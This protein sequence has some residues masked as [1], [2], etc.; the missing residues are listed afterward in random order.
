MNM[1]TCNGRIQNINTNNLMN[2]LRNNGVGD[3]KETNVSTPTP[4]NTIFNLFETSKNDYSSETLNELNQST[5]NSEDH[6]HPNTQEQK[7][8]KT[9][10]TEEK[11]ND[12]DNG[13]E[14]KN[15][16]SEKNEKEEKNE[17][18]GKGRERETEDNEE[19]N[20]NE[21]ENEDKDKEKF[22]EKL[23]QYK[24]NRKDSYPP[25]RYSTHYSSQ[26]S[27]DTSSH[28][29]FQSNDNIF[30]QN[31]IDESEA[32]S[33]EEVDK[34][35]EQKERKRELE[36]DKELRNLNEKPLKKSH[37]HLYHEENYYHKRYSTHSSGSLNPNPIPNSN[38]LSVNT[39]MDNDLFTL[40]EVD[41]ILEGNKEDKEKEMEKPKEKERVSKLKGYRHQVFREDS[42]PIKR[43]SNYLSTA[44]KVPNLG[45]E[46]LS[47]KPNNFNPIVISNRNSN[48]SPNIHRDS[49]T[50]TPVNMNLIPKNSSSPNIALA[51]INP[52]PMTST[53]GK[54]NIALANINPMSMALA[55]SPNSNNININTIGIPNYIM[56]SEPSSY[57]SSESQYNGS[58]SFSQSSGRKFSFPHHSL[59]QYDQFK[60]HPLRKT[61]EPL[62]ITQPSQQP[63][64][65]QS[66]TQSQ[67]Q[68]QNQHQ[69]QHQNQRQTHFSLHS[70]TTTKIS[71][72]DKPALYPK[73]KQGDSGSK[74]ISSLNKP[75]LLNKYKTFVE[76]QTSEKLSLNYFGRSKSYDTKLDIFNPGHPL[77][78][79]S[80]NI[81][82]LDEIIGIDNEEEEKK[83]KH[84]SI[85]LKNNLH[86]IKSRTSFRMGFKDNYLSNDILIDV[87][88]QG[89]PFHVVY[90]VWQIQQKFRS[91]RK[92]KK[93]I[94]R[95]KKF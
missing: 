85:N 74:T 18:K 58:L 78:D 43:N 91:S 79:I 13:E 86:R 1:H 45:N 70:S 48:S 72:D 55:D 22:K 63:S 83:N 88:K 10:K 8:E 12:D 52:M 16:K 62:P 34:I 67:T 87:N 40:N 29:N 2:I 92:E 94:E 35:L 24:F 54:P 7:I 9:E 25:K 46:T 80:R 27:S 60:I 51:N 64:Q 69:H 84:R 59:S 90:A 31:R 36:R 41:R 75:K 50:V 61:T 38:F 26:Y 66:Q 21:N 19:K 77:D 39:I 82:E 37:P 15:E 30:D 42:Y 56:T 28:S 81:I 57:E 68:Q 44:T 53:T 76:T 3:D 17:K 95:K 23:T 93:I 20:K 5:K 14:G 71:Y 32:F 49:L 33:L 65:S 89:L 6:R 73:T 4:T 11:K 47:Y